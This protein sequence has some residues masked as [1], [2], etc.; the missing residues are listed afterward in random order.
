L[1]PPL[2]RIT[3]TATAIWVVPVGPL[4]LLP[5]HLARRPD[6]LAP[7]GY[8]YLIDDRSVSI[9]PSAAHAA[10][11]AGGADG[12]LGTAVPA[13]IVEAWDPALTGAKLECHV[14][15]GMF[16]TRV[17]SLPPEAATKDAVL[18][19]LRDAEVAHVA[20][21][22]VANL[23]SPL[24]SALL[25]GAHE[26]ITVRDLLVD[27]GFSPRLV[28]LSACQSAMSGVRLPDEAVS[29]PTALLQAGAGATIGSL[30]AVPD[31]PTALL[32]ARFYQLW[33]REGHDAP[34]ALRLA[35]IWLRDSPN[36]EH[37]TR[38]PSVDRRTARL[39]PDVAHDWRERRGY[40][41]PDFWGGF[42]FTGAWSSG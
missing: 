30:W 7:T 35:Q 24:D 42:V 11:G 33:Q 3:G 2:I 5:L 32:M 31:A 41:H 37:A 17:R 39:L 20:C 28:V 38:F 21:H 12:Q 14:I 40:A 8:R 25:I 1:L 10:E 36:A 18:A 19:A 4:A 27:A 22:G 16:G 26:E 6:S 34:Q 13:V 9:L 15:A 29:L 23:L